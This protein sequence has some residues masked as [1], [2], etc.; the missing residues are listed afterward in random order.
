V[1]YGELKSSL[2]THTY[3]HQAAA[4]VSGDAAPV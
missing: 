1:K 4:P 2:D 3:D